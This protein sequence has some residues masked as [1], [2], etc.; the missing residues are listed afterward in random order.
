MCRHTSA[1]ND[2]LVFQNQR[3]TE[4]GRTIAMFGQ[5]SKEYYYLTFEI[6][7]IFEDGTYVNFG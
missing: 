7:F 6:D 4:L 3:T 2:L 5:C 1:S